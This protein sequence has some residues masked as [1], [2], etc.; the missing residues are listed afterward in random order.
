MDPAGYS[1]DYEA[2]LASQ[3]ISVRFCQI[4]NGPGPQGAFDWC[5]GDV[6]WSCSCQASGSVLCTRCYD[7]MRIHRGA[8]QMARQAWLL[9][10]IQQARA[11]RQRRR[12]FETRRFA[13]AT[14][15]YFETAA[16]ARGTVLEQL[17]PSLSG[18]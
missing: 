2:N 16:T 12:A 13:A 4:R 7:Q 11:Q 5:G 1:T 3:P 18:A 15:D 8:T 10:Q 6:H 9:D 17:D 14:G